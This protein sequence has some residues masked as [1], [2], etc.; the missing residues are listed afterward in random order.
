M[1]TR[2]FLAD[3]LWPALVLEQRLLSAIP[4]TVGLGNEWL[5][6]RF[7]GFGLSWKKAVVVD[8]V[9]NTVSSVAGILL[10]AWSIDCG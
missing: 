8:L 4:I 9:M 6:L 1:G 3:M 7:G 10:M 5:A 2:V